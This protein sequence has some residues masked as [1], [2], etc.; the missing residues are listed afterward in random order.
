MSDRVTRVAI[1]GAN[2]FVGR[3]LIQRMG[4]LGGFTVT[5]ITR[6]TDGTALPALLADTDHVI[7][8]AGVNRSDD[9][10]AYM[11]GN[12]G[13]TQ[14]LCDALRSIGRP[15]PL[16]YASSARAGE[17]TPYG[18][19]K[20]AAED[21]VVAYGRETGAPAHFA[22]IDNI[23][24]KWTRPNYNS[25][26]ATFCH[27]IARG[28]PVMVNDPA[29][30]LSLIYI[31]DLVDA[32][33]GLLADA[34]PPPGGL[35]SFGPVHRTTVGE[36]ADALHMIHA[37][38]AAM[39]IPAT[40]SGFMRALYATYISYLPPAD[41][42]YAVP[43]HHDARGDFVEMLKTHD[44]GQFSYF[45]SHPGVTR[46]DHYHHSK[47]EKFLVLSGTAHFGF[48][49]IVTGETH[50]LIVTGGEARI[51]ETI[52]GWTHNITN[53]GDSELVVMLWANEVYDRDRPDTIAMK[54]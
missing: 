10:D 7:H 23:F 21:I 17:P 22:R 29:A 12:A 16:F 18:Q 36:V 42:S 54:V 41:F 47:V 33:V 4:E 31:D 37:G 11:P 9:A 5:A 39:R 48:R 19:S 8:L 27:N 44:S 26:V 34:A 40:G 6:D 25:A 3:N 20:R 15:V 1:T 2:G 38:R 51:V 14:T 13:A 28:L 52:P 32:L 43:R 46:G 49:Q 30:T 45:T 35:L 24:G 53:V 50:E